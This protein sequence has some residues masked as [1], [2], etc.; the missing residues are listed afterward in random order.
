MCIANAAKHSALSHTPRHSSGHQLNQV[1]KGKLLLTRTRFYLIHVTCY[2]SQTSLEG[3]V[4]REAK[5][6][7]FTN[8]GLMDYIIELVICKDEVSKTSNS[9]TY[10]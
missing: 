5:S 6:P 9:L 4:T 3:V 7:L 2:S 10:H 1:S 8:A